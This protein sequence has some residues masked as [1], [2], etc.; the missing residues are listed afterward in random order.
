M[1]VDEGL[2]DNGRVPLGAADGRGG[3]GLKGLL[4]ELYHRESGVR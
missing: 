1:E 3:W 4:V 2:D